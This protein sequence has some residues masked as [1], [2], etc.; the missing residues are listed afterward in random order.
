MKTNQPSR[1]A[2]AASVCAYFML[3]AGGLG[4]A[5]SSTGNGAAHSSK[6]RLVYVVNLTGLSADERFTAICLQG[7]ANRKGPRVYLNPGDSV[8]WMQLPI[9][10][11]S[12]PSGN[13][14][15]A[16]QMEAHYKSIG[17][18]WMDELT[19]RHIC[20]FETMTLGG[21][22]DKLRPEISGRIA[23]GSVDDD[24]SIAATL[25]GVKSAVPMTDATYNALVASRG[26]SMP[27]TFD[28]RSLYTSYDASS[29]KRIAAHQWMV[30]HLLRECDKSGAIS[31]NKTYGLDLHDTIVDVDLGVAHKWAT[32][33][34]NYLSEQTRNENSK[35]DPT[36]GFSLPDTPL[37]DK[38]LTSLKPL[39]PV[40]GWGSPDENNTCRRITIDNCVL[41]CGGTGNGSFYER[42][43]LMA[44]TFRQPGPRPEAG[45]PANKIYIAFMTNEGDSLKNTST[46]QN[47][48]WAQPERGT[49]PVNWGI[50]PLICREFPG[51]MSYYTA[52]AT[53][54]D[55]YFAAASGW[56]YTHPE[57]FADDRV[58]EYANQ[59][60]KACAGCDTPI[61]DIWWANG[62]RARNLYFPFLHAAGVKGL[63]S[64]SDHQ[65][66]E[67]SP[68][69]GMPIVHSNYYYAL[70]KKTPE[71]FAAA[72]TSDLAAIK[73]PWFV[74]VYGGTPYKFAEVAK[75]LPASRFEPVRLDRFFEL[76]KKARPMVEGK[77]WK[78]GNPGKPEAAPGAGDAQVK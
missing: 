9:G 17:D 77:I 39:S 74:V 54:N 15:W 70:D 20:S 22:I 72:M 46:F 64:W 28:V 12:N 57:R 14:A 62:L 34:L 3:L 33:D 52:T 21:L 16:A 23:Y 37:I 60:K 38:V 76:A 48:S 44:G 26:Q 4:Y 68:L 75:H 66:I 5:A 78:P 6:G 32:F 55:Y 73:G 1:F 2:A 11:S 50:D 19:A 53:P 24:I 71:Q 27:T 25:A 18:Y 69:D 63:T 56:G 7:L 61:I 67:Y 58:L 35:P 59:V 40:Y 49:L 65:G 47:L 29:S 31:R 41:V 10:K 13:P 8:R 36:Y 42:L 51:M 30:D 45:E 43:P